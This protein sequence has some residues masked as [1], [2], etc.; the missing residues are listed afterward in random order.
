M[1]S[2]IQ[3]METFQENNQL[4]CHGVRG[5][6]KTYVCHLVSQSCC[7]GGKSYRHRLQTTASRKEQG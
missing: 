7:V 3:G 1:I 2:K 4:L 5:Q 6:S